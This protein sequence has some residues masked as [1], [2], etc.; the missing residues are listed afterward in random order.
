LSSYREKLIIF[1][2]RKGGDVGLHQITAV[3]RPNSVEQAWSEKRDRGNRACFLGGGIDLVNFASPSVTTLIDLRGLRLSFVHREE[4]DVVVGATA[5]MTEI[6]ESDEIKRYADGFLVGV[7]RQVASPLQRNAATLGGTIA[8]AHPWSDVIPALLVL[9][10]RV[11]IFDGEERIVLLEQYFR[12]RTKSDRPLITA[13]RLPRLGEE[14][15]ATFE[16]FSRTRFDVG[17]LNC[18]CLV[19]TNEGRCENV[20]VAIGGTP[21]LATRLSRVE[22]TLL[23][24]TLDE[25]AIETA[26]EAAAGAVDARDDR[27]ASSDYRRLLA[28]IGVKRCLARIA[29]G[30]EGDAE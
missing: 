6:T 2:E 17:M 13:I 28:R 20:R 15:S 10:A 9:D 22:E 5:T 25:T 3:V 26:A 24:N 8:S 18:A 19:Q 4:D 16:K 29:N 1:S 27:R 14:T 11:S 21:S 12:R 23:E 7:L 30:R